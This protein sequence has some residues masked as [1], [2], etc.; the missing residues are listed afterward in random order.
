MFDRTITDW[1]PH[2][3]TMEDFWSS[4]ALLSGRYHGRPMPVHAKLDISPA[5]FDR[6]L[7]LFSDTATEICPPAAAAFFTDRARNIARSLLTGLETL[8][9]SPVA[10]AP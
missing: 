5:Q 6:W 7:L 2:L 4:V 1:E 8:K 9:G 3:R 10:L